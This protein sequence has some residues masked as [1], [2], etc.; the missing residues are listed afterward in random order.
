MKSVARW[1]AFN[2][3]YNSLPVAD[4]IQAIRVGFSANH[5]HELAETLNV[6]QAVISRLVGLSPSAAKRR[7]TLNRN[8]S[9]SASERLLQIGVVETRTVAV[10]GSADRAHE[11]LRT[12]NLSLGNVSP[13]SMLDTGPGTQEVARILN[14]IEHGGTA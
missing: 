12:R 6:P 1:K 2:E 14:A 5:L 11:W 9:P 4:R 3:Y 8:L 10:F 7:I 13:L